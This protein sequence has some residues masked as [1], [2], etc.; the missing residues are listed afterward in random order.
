MT[1]ISLTLHDHHTIQ[2]ATREKSL[3]C[4][5]TPGLSED[6]QYHVRP[7]SILCLKMTKS[8]IRPQ[9]KWAVSLVIA[10]GPF[11]LPRGLCEYV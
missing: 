9:V 7:H 5:K 4:L 3:Y 2:Q 6:T 10:E 8:D 11:N 1:E